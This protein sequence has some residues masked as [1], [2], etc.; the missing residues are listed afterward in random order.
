MSRRFVYSNTSAILH[1]HV[2]LERPHIHKLLEESVR[3]PLV[4]VI[5]GAGYGKT[6]AVY[7]FLKKYSAVTAWIQLSERDNL[8]SRFWE[9]YTYTISLYNKKLATK[10]TEVGFPETE[11]QFHRYL[12]IPEDENVPSEKYVFVFDDFYLIQDFFVLR[13]LERSVN[14]IFPNVTTILISRNEPAINTIGLLSK[15]LRADIDEKDLRFTQDEMLSYFQ[16]QGINPSPQAVSDIYNGTEGWA[17]AIGL[18][19]LSLKK[20]PVRESYALSAMKTNIF[21]WIESEIFFGISEELQ[22]FLVTLSLVDHLSSDFVKELSSG[23]NFMAETAKLGSFIRYDA[24]L[25]EYRIHHLFLDYLSQR[26][27]MLTEDEKRGVYVKAA[28]WCVENNYKMDAVSYCAKAQEYDWLIEIVYTLQLMLPNE[29]ALFLLELFEKIPKDAYEKN[30][31]LY[32]L[33]ARFLGSLGRF[34]EAIF[35]LKALIGKLEAQPKSSFSCR[36]LCG[37]Y[38][39][40]GFFYYCS[41]MHTHDYRFERYFEKSAHYHPLSEHV[42]KGPVTT[43]SVGSYV[44]RIGESRESAIEK[45]IDSVAASVPHV[46]NTMN[47]CAHGL[48]ELLRAEVAYFKSDVKNCEKFAYLALYKA[49]EKDQHEIENRALFL[50]LRVALG[51]GNYPQIQNLCKQLELQLDKTDYINRRTH[52]DIVMGWYYITIKQPQQVSHW[53]KNDFDKSDINFLMQGQENVVKV[54]YYWSEKKYHALLAFLKSQENGYGLGAFLFGKIGLKI[55]EASCQ[56]HLNEKEA[57]MKAFRTAYELA[58]PD[59]LDMFFIEQGSDMR[60]LTTSAMKNKNCTI[61]QQWLEKIRK[62]STTYA[63]KLAYVI[64]EYKDANHLG[65]EIHLT[66]R[67]M[68]ILIDLRHGLSRTEIAANR[69]LSI[70][71]VKAAIQMIYTKLRATDGTDAIRIATSLKLLK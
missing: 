20:K 25:N 41:C 61:P 58:E 2:Y 57:A 30:G 49:R 1:E 62:K 9:N 53:L 59:S 32:L 51:A 27:G 19:G 16:M 26:Q 34:D 45:F 71:T 67:E 35:N 10:L 63:K 6:E 60:T 52:Y 33:Y 8:G 48:D 47:G 69:N 13:F 50:L 11:S 21:K 65:N 40:L 24:Y 7:S 42:V 15:G 66:T 39:N 18:V 14:T 54:R 17:F 37:A 23:K 70:N 22:K 31:T 5:A 64:S 68:E 55:M 44:C 36:L 46:A 29:T 3:N 56:Y 38:N 43:L 4:T 28:R 12:V